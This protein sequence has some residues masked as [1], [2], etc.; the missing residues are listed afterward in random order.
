MKRAFVIMKDNHGKVNIMRHI[1][2]L[3]VTLKDYSVKESM[4]LLDQYLNNGGLNTASYVSTQMLVAA[5]KDE[6]VKSTLESFDITV[7]AELDIL[8]AAEIT[9]RS[10]IHEVEN[11][12]FMNELLKK[13]VR[14]KKTIYLLGNTEQE[15]DNLEAYLRDYQEH[16]TIVGKYANEELN[17][18]AVI[19]DINSVAPT[20]IISKLPFDTQQPFLGEER[21]MINGELWLILTSDT[22]KPFNKKRNPFYRMARYIYHKLFKRKVNKYKN[23]KAE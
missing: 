1:N 17:R 21:K 10:R 5:G 13:L 19:N 14:T 16:I 18:D 4:K 7:L 3:G 22:V 2:I 23:E 12:E 9:L 8:H 20:V 15:L 6:N 11:N